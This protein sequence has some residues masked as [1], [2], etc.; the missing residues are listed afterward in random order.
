MG[1]DSRRQKQKGARASGGAA[2]HGY[3]R[4]KEKNE[5]D[6]ENREIER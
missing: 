3:R 4:E 6:R 2:L 5:E 1:R